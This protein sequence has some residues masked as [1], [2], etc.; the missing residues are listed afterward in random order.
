M[1]SEVIAAITMKLFVFWVVISC[2]L[3]Y[4]NRLPGVI[5]L[6]TLIGVHVLFSVL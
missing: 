4:A 3:V 1:K 5:N 6:T 2:G